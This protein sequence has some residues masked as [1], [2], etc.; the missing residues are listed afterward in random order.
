V[1]IDG[2]LPVMQLSQQSFPE[3]AYLHL[4]GNATTE[5]TQF[6]I[7]AN[8]KIGLEALVLSVRRS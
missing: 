7:A 8:F 1:L 6:A 4:V 2:T 5:K 3:K